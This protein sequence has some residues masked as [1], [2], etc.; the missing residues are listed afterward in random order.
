M[1]VG[2]QVSCKILLELKR[3]APMFFEVSCS[4]KVAAR[5]INFSS[6][7]TFDTYI[8]DYSYDLVK[9]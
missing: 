4:L 1:F 9:L 2:K 7:D 6:S 3:G 5:R 8:I